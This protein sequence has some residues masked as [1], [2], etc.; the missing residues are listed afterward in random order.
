M[1]PRPEDIGFQA[2]SG[3]KRTETQR[4]QR[5]ARLQGIWLLPITFQMQSLTI[6]SVD[7]IELFGVRRQNSQ[8]ANSTSI[9]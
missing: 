3:I 8:V 6:L 9:N 1:L 5:E 2:F 7:L 4:Q